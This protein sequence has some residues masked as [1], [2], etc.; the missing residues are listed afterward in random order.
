[1]QQTVATE[2][3]I[4][5]ETFVEWAE[6]QTEK[7]TSMTSRVIVSNDE[8]TRFRLREG[9]SIEDI[10]L[11]KG[12]NTDTIRFEKD[13]QTRQFH[14]HRRNITFH[15]KTL[16]VRTKDGQEICRAGTGTKNKLG[17]FPL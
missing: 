13:G 8:M 4:D 15:D 16:I 17:P 11:I 3:R 6:E 7:S 14:A 2:N 12:K 10:V 9:N 5:T 1:M